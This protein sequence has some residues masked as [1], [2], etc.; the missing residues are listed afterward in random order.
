MAEEE[1]KSRTAA[2]RTFIRLCN[3]ITLDIQHRSSP[4]V[5]NEKYSTLKLLWDN[6][7]SKH[8]DYLFAIHPDEEEPSSPADVGY[9]TQL[10][11]KF[12][13]IQKLKYD[14]THKMSLKKEG[15]IKIAEILKSEVEVIIDTK[16][17]DQKIISEQI[18]FSQE[19]DNLNDMLKSDIDGHLK[20]Q[21]NATLKDLKLRLDKCNDALLT[22][23]RSADGTI[24][25]DKQKSIDGLYR[26][27]KNVNQRCL[28]YFED[29]S[30]RDAERQ[31]KPV[32]RLE[33]M[34]LKD[35]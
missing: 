15:D 9:I 22:Y 33:R 28:A 4:E 20:R 3:R 7:Q 14:Y 6:V 1:K 35:K 8:D 13:I 24:P 23:L 29:V 25:P 26:S 2:K 21:V 34:F 18:L 16:I 12:E 10:E 30:K 27:Y 32:V 11:E 31:A 17:A 5:I 19:V